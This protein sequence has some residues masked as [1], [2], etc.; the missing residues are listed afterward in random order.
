MATA[1][2]PVDVASEFT[3]DVAAAVAPAA[4]FASA[5]ASASAIAGSV[6]S[7][8]WRFPLLLENPLHAKIGWKDV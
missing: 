6:G 1:G 8:H 7:V 3:N 2:N 5:S 4:G